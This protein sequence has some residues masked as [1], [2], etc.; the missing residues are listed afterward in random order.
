MPLNLRI[1]PLYTIALFAATVSATLILDRRAAF[2]PLAWRAGLGLAIALAA[3]AAVEAVL[4][5]H[6]YNPWHH[7][8]YLAGLLP[9]SAALV[10][11]PF[12]FRREIG[13]VAKYLRDRS[14]LIAIGSV[15]IFGLAAMFLVSGADLALLWLG[16]VTS[17]TWRSV[18][19]APWAWATNILI[20]FTALLLA[21]GLTA[22]IGVALLLV[23][24][25]YLALTAAT[26]GKLTYMHTAVQPL[27]LLRL[28]E[29][30]P[31]FAP[32]F[33]S[34][35]VACT[36]AACVLWIV[37]IVV[38]FRREPARMTYRMRSALAGAALALLMAVPAAFAASAASPGLEA[39][40]VRAGGPEGHFKEQAKRNGILL[41]FLAEVPSIAVRRPSAYN[42]PEARLV[43]ARYQ[44]MPA[45]PTRSPRVRLIIYL[46]ESFMDP[47]ELGVRYTAEPIPNFVTMWK[48]H[49]GGHVVVPDRFGGSANTEFELLTGMTMAFLPRESLPY[50]QY[51]RRPLPSLPWQLKQ[52]GYRTVAVQ[53]DPKF[54]YDRER[55]YR[56]LGFDRVMWLDEVPGIVRDGRVGWPAD[57]TV[58]DAIIEASQD[59][60]P[61]FIFA[62]PASTHSYYRSGMFRSSPLAPVPP[63]A[64]DSAGEV[65]EYV[66]ALHIADRELGELVR[67]FKESPDST[68]IAVLGDHLPPLS[69]GAL[70]G[71]QQSIDSLPAVERDLRL[72]RVPL[73]VWSNFPLPQERPLLSTSA[74]PSYLLEKLALPGYG[75]LAASDTVRRRLPVMGRHARTIDG[76]SW[77]LDSLPASLDSM[78][79]RYELLQY[80]LLLGKGYTIPASLGSGYSADPNTTGRPH[81]P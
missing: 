66:N 10:L 32:T 49:I 29:F 14:H 31:L 20:L 71:F 44:T 4:S 48:S 17:A 62:F 57:R 55:A 80:D 12:L 30:L 76:H 15:A 73:L 74:L 59:D 81:L 50:R 25:A 40:L 43:A 11:M 26:M 51:L 18:P 54:Y 75:I 46:I 60:R 53:P 63:L 69:S 41:S 79:R 56:L 2:A 16:R 9:F 61:S 36:L 23:G 33:G 13:L 78:V 27:D 22:R 6:G 45:L 67:H 28:P 39:W 70:T 5:H 42:A 8:G 38:A 68:V 35:V 24:P 64:S 52:M 77:D 65:Q 21:Y 1:D 3:A 7:S 37:A 72:R 58:V 34:T 47:H 19:L